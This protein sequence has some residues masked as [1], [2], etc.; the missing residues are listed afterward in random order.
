MFVIMDPM[1][2]KVRFQ[3]D[4]Q[5]WCSMISS[6]TFGGCIMWSRTHIDYGRVLLLYGTQKSVRWC[7]FMHYP[8]HLSH[9][10]S[11]HSIDA[12][13]KV[14]NLCK[15]PPGLVLSASTP[16]TVAY[17]LLVLPLSTGL[18]LSLEIYHNYN[19]AKAA[20][21]QSFPIFGDTSTKHWNVK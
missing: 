6:S 8:F 19:T 9:S 1:G 16:M 13:L 3:C 10:H 2:S 15:A 4:P 18:S 7:S 20:I 12:W 21:G 11:I 5:T 14:S 17:C